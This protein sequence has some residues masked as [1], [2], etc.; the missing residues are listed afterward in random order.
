ML[1]IHEKLIE[2][3]DKQNNIIL[4]KQVIEA[5]DKK[6]IEKDTWKREN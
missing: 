3:I 2:A 1:N 4:Q 6:V 5:I